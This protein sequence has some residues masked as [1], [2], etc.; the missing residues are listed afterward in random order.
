MFLAL[1]TMGLDDAV[2]REYRL[3]SPSPLPAPALNALCEDA[4][5]KPEFQFALQR[6]G[7]CVCEP[8]ADLPVAGCC[9]VQCAVLCCS[10][11]L[12]RAV[13]WRISA[14]CGGG[15]V[16]TYICA[17]YIVDGDDARKAQHHTTT[18]PHHHTTPLPVHHRDPRHT[19][20]CRRCRCSAV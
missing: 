17:M 13:S 15:G 2:Q 11:V 5:A 10:A 12:C 20:R 4:M 9:A 14:C 3:P 18:L 8:V 7:P 16:C 1:C 6:G 19:R